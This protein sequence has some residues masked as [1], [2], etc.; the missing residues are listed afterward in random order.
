[1]ASDIESK[2]T[3]NRM[4]FE[5]FNAGLFVDRVLIPAVRS[6]TQGPRYLSTFD[7]LEPLTAEYLKRKGVDIKPKAVW[8]AIQSRIIAGEREDREGEK[9]ILEENQEI[10]ERRLLEKIQ[11]G[12]KKWEDALAQC[13]GK[14]NERHAVTRPIMSPLG[15]LTITELKEHKLRINDLLHRMKREIDNNKE[16]GKQALDDARRKVEEFMKERG[17]FDR[18]G[19]YDFLSGQN[20][21]DRSL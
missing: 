19:L 2:R 14:V 5:E 20:S 6:L 17:I 7:V 18:A 4:E 13:D 1:M 15:L 8:F 10:E 16:K 9:N 21:T 12:V 11:R 3:R